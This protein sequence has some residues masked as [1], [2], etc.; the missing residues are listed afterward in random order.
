MR[1]SISLCFFLAIA[2]LTS[3][4]G[5]GKG[6]LS[7]TVTFENKKVCSGSVLV[8][9]GD[10]IIKPAPISPDGAYL[11]KDIA[12]GSI[13]IFVNSPQPGVVAENRS[14]RAGKQGAPSA[15]PGDSAA[16]FPIPAQYADLD[17][18][19]LTFTLRS[20]SNRFDIDLK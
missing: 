14:T 15:T 16:W 17:K 20:G 2:F 11:V 6:S 9:G 12:V 4:C 8:R 7:G 5:S 18:S 13:R 19:P 3:G 10:G 1:N